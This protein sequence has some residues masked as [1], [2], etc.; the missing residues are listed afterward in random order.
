MPRCLFTTRSSLRRFG[1]HRLHLP[2]S[3]G[4]ASQVH[5]QPPWQ[6]PPSP[7]PDAQK[8]LPPLTIWN[9][10]TR[11]KTPFVPLD[12]KKKRV[13]WYA[14]GPTVYDDAHLGHA[15]NFVSTDI[16][17]RIMKDYFKFDVMFVMNVTDVD[18]KVCLYVRSSGIVTNA[19]H[20][21]LFSAQDSSIFSRSSMTLPG[22]EE[23]Q[24]RRIRAL[25][26]WD[27]T[28]KRTYHFCPPIRHLEMFRS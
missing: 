25:R 23:Q 15:R 28:C 6:A 2:R 13:T 12:S 1:Y 27:T 22:G 21:R 16:I 8:Q 18:D 19:L 9:S 10:L 4:M 3:V 24:M 17:R 14:C 20:C 7:G 11:S 5:Q 26:H